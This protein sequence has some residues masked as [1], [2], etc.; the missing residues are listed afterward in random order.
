LWPRRLL[1][2][3][4]RWFFIKVVGITAFIWIFFVAYFKVL[5]DVSY[6]VTQ[7][8]LLWLDHALPF[9]PAA[10]YVYLS[11]WFYVGLAPG[12]TFTLR[13]LFMYGAWSL[14]LCLLGLGIFHFWPTAVPLQE[15]DLSRYPAF[16]VL[17]GV[18][19][20]GN[21]CPSMHVAAAMFAAIRIDSLFRGQ[22]LPAWL[23][24]ANVV[25]LL[26]IA[27]STVAVRQH[28]TLDVLAG[29][30]LGAAVALASLRWPGTA[31]R[32]PLSL[33]KIFRR[34]R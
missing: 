4:R 28:V 25:W 9:E 16:A 32:D 10:L 21:A 24:A 13:Q 29:A 6:P 20:S 17:R 31:G 14:V 1:G 23:R 34:L 11:L 15:I 7:M 8:P 2:L 5:R 12:L 33:D 30:L 3:A 26:A 22:R 19:A 27:W 18:D